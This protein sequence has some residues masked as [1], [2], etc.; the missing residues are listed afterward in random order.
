MT[1]IVVV[2]VNPPQMLAPYSSTFGP[3]QLYRCFILKFIIQTC[4]VIF[5]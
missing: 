3:T 2:Q 1:V 4:D 5:N